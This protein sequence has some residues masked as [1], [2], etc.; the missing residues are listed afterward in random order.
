MRLLV[1]LIFLTLVGGLNPTLAAPNTDPGSEDFP[2][3]NSDDLDIIY[4]NSVREAK[5]FRYTNSY[6][7]TTGVI[8]G[9]YTRD[10]DSK[11]Q[12]TL[13]ASWVGYKNEKTAW[14]YGADIVADNSA[15]VRA[16]HMWYFSTPQPTRF[17]TELGGACAVV[18]N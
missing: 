3:L 2:A 9:S 15:I 18:S 12:S 1:L 11:I 6:N 7:F 5:V 17:F 14:E 10:G 4:T 8:L 13:G 16:G